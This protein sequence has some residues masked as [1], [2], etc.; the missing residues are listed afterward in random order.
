MMSASVQRRGPRNSQHLF[1][2]PCHPDRGNE[3][4]ERSETDGQ[5]EQQ[6]AFGRRYACS[7]AS[8]SCSL[9]WGGRLPFLQLMNVFAGGLAG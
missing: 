9:A 4:S 7:M 1:P 6:A 8:S 2:T 3:L 5:Q